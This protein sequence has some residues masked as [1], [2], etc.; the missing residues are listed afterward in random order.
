MD[1]IHDSPSPLPYNAQELY[2]LIHS[3]VAEV[4][5]LKAHR[6]RQS[7]YKYAEPEAPV[8]KLAFDETR[9]ALYPNG[10]ASA[11]TFFKRTDSS[12][13]AIAGVTAEV[14]KRLHTL[15]QNPHQVYSASAA[16]EEFPA[17]SRYNSTAKFILNYP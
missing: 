8:Q 9:E 1:D 6:N 10:V 16:F 15:P 13:R 11:Q 3:L 2:S 7:S 5:E 14:S 17:P 4:Q 12:Q